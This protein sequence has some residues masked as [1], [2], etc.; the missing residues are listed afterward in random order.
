MKNNSI[1]NYQC[2]AACL[3]RYINSTQR[4]IY[5]KTA[6]SLLQQLKSWDAAKELLYIQAVTSAG[7][8]A[9]LN[10]KVIF[11]VFIYRPP[12]L[13]LKI[14]LCTLQYIYKVGFLNILKC[15]KYS[16]QGSQPC[17]TL[18]KQVN[19]QKISS[20]YDFLEGQETLSYLLTA[21]S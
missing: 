21:K 11:K 20:I 13:S 8:V 14:Y 3:F 10:R 2:K 4:N 1:D 17:L 7:F 18:L 15:F 16:L 9:G 12:D 19:I 5:S 6:I